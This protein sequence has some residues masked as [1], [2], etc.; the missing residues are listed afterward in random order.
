MVIVVFAED[1]RQR[2][3]ALLDHM[4]ERFPQITSLY[5]VVNTKLN[6][7]ISDL[8][9]TLYRGRE[10]ILERMEGLLFRVGPKSFYQ[11][12]SEQA[13]ELYKV[14]R[15]FAGLTGSETVYDLYTGRRELA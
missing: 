9:H 1:D 13:Y 11:T 10:H 8:Q 6:D 12:N 15:N 5:Y 4:S 7:S 3:T 2:I 14:A